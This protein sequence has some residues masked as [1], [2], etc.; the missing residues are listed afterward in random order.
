MKPTPWFKRSFSPITDNDQ[1]PTI[2]ER[3]NSM[4]TRLGYAI[5]SIESSYYTK[6]YDTDKWSIQEQVGHLLE[7]EPLWLGRMEDIQKE[8]LFLRT[9]DLTNQATYDAE[10]NE[11]SISDILIAFVRQ[12]FALVDFLENVT[13]EDFNKSALH[14]RLQTPMKII[15]L[16]FFVAEHDDHHLAYIDWIYQRLS[17]K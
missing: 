1:L 16:A 9:A 14:P 7:L 11:Q 6:K 15:D 12:R 5:F 10:Y 2:I 13:A 3:L 17:K 8:L 4:S